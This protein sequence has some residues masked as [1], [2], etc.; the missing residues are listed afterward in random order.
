MNQLIVEVKNQY[1]IPRIFPVCSISQTVAALAKT[2]TFSTDDIGRI[3]SLGYDI[4]VQQEI[5]KL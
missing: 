2:K 5:V 1:G 3:K 4:K